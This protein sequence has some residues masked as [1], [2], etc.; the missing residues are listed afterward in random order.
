MGVD[1][2]EDTGE[3]VGLSCTAVVSCT[4]C[5]LVSISKAVFP[6]FMSPILAPALDF[7]TPR[8]GGLRLQMQ[9]APKKV[10]ATT[11]RMGPM[12]M[13][14]LLTGTNVPKANAPTKVMLIPASMMHSPQAQQ[15]AGEGSPCGLV[16]FLLGFWD[17]GV[18][19]FSLNMLTGVSGLA[20]DL[21]ENI[22][23][24]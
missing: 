14:G 1:F 9:Q 15:R 4:V 10:N 2:L 20:L 23:C 17:K 5:S 21:T 11:K 7:L 22:W 13:G 24:P 3:L 18:L 16:F 19:F 12:T 6:G 8:A